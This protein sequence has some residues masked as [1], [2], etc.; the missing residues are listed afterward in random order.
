[1]VTAELIKLIGSADWWSSTI[2]YEILN[3]NAIWRFGLVALVVLIAMAG[4]RIAQFAVNSLALRKEAARG[5]TIVTLL[6]RCISKPISVAVFALGLYLCKLCLVFEDLTT[7]PPIKGIN[8]VF[9][10]GW[11]QVI[12]AVAAIAVAYAV[13][14]LVDIVEFYLTRWT[15]KTKTKLDD[16][17]VPVVRKSLRV[18]IAILA[19]L[20]IADGILGAQIRTILLGAGVGGIAIALAAKE[21]IANFFGSL[22]IFTDRPFQIDELIDIEGNMGVVEDVGFRSTRIRT[23]E[24]HLVTV[25]NSVVTN[26]VVKNIGRRPF[27]RRTSNIT[28]TYDSGH[29]KTHR[30][31]EIIKEIL[32]QVPEVNT[33]PEKPPRVYFS[34]FND[35][36]LNIYM[37]YWVRPADY[38]LYHQVNERV[39]FEI[40]KRFEAEKTD[41]AFPSRTLYIKK[42]D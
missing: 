27:I 5:T 21:T 32:A 15:S 7:T 1:M 17:L 28:I 12:K 40:M 8:A 36:S 35:S 10:R 9:G 38:W 29:A 14:R 30:A 18:T 26:T 11:S 39:N 16:M 20:W 42:T 22:T 13:Y 34:D 2:N 33:D 19:T 3:G 37:S 23:L 4:G 25:P 41:F 24:G 6:L 31:V